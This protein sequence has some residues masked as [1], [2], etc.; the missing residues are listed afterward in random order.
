MNSVGWRIVVWFLAGVAI[1]TII[2]NW[3]GIWWDSQAWQIVAAIGTWI[4]AG[5]VVFAFLQVRQSRKSTNA[6]IAVE[7]FRELRG[8]DNISG[9]RAI[10]S[11]T[12]DKF[13]NLSR[14]ILDQIDSVLER[15][16]MLGGLV[17]KGII[18]EEL[19]IENF[20]G[21]PAM[22]CWYQLAENLIRPRQGERGWYCENYEDFTR[23]SLDYFKKTNNKIWFYREPEKDKRIDLVAELQKDKLRPRS[24]KEIKK[25][26]KNRA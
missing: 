10:Y 13:A 2:R 25:E 22:R 7:L 4:L 1:Y 9:L 26:R 15:L 18:D 16:D 23:R 24:L 8:T 21:P 17:A 12:P 19:A 14:A 20:A 5:G 6:Q 11:L 3:G